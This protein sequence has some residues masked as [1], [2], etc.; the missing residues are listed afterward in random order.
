[1]PH[2]K[3]SEYEEKAR[4]VSGVQEYYHRK[5]RKHQPDESRINKRTPFCGQEKVRTNLCYPI[6]DILSVQLTRRKS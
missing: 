6:L 5:T 2:S 4:A 3:F 1:M